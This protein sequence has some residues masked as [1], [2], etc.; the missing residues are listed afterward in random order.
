MLSVTSFRIQTNKIIVFQSFASLTS[1][2]TIIKLRNSPFSLHIRCNL[3]PKNLHY[4]SHFHHLSCS[5]S[6]CALE[7]L[8]LCIPFFKLN[9]LK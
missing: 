4:K 9:Y 7:K 1:P 2:Y 6:R 3:N 8:Y 5:N